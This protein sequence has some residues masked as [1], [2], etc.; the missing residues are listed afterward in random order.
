MR[1]N[2]GWPEIAPDASARRLAVCLFALILVVAG[3][4]SDGAEDDSGADSAPRSTPVAAVTVEPRDL[5]RELRVSGTV[6]PRVRV[7]LASQIA[8]RVADVAVEVGDTVETDEVVVT[9]DVAEQRAELARA[10]A[11]AEEARVTYRR[12]AELR[13]RGVASPAEYERARAQLRVAESEQALWA[14]RVGFGSLRAPMASVVTARHIEAGEAVEAQDTVLELSAMDDLIIRFGVSELDVVHLR[15][16]DAVAVTLDALPEDP[17]AAHVRRIHPAADP[18]SRLVDVEVSLPADAADRGIR[19]G[20][21]GRLRMALDQRA[22]VLAV[23]AAAVGRG[24]D[25]AYVYAIV[26][27]HL[28]RRSVTTGVSRGDWTEIVTG[29]EAGSVV[30]ASNPVDM[31][32][33]T[34]V[35]IV[36]RRG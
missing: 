5:S 34:R 27:D 25:G 12:T 4:D 1:R 18:A 7:R 32:E 9:L 33:G 21:L 10:E 19:A 3:C 36:G 2:H 17:V 28:S 16:G 30:L 22:G 15:V 8:G 29:L 14:T 31:A 23:P 35:R 6:E 13:E 24:D 11:L 26:D 20:Y